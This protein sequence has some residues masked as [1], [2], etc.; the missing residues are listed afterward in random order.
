MPSVHPRR[1]AQRRDRRPRRPRQDH[2]RRRHA[3][4]VRRL[5]RPPGRRGLGQ[6]AGHGLDGPR[7]REG[8]HDPRQEHRGPV[9][10]RRAGRRRDDQHHRH[11]R[12]RRLR[13]RGRARPGDGRR[14]RCCSSTPARARCRRPGS[15]CAR[16]CR[17]GCRSSW[18]STRSTAPTRA[19]PRS[20]TRP[21]SC[22]STSTPTRSR[23][24]SRS[25]TPRPRPAGPSL[26]RPADGDDARLPT[27]SSRCSTTIL[28][29]DPGARRTTEGAPLQAHVTNL[30]ASP[31]LGRLALCRVHNG[32]IRKGQTGRLVPRRRHR[33]SGS[34]SPSC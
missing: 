31:Y 15:C 28:E 6:R 18:S 5:H 8:H 14:R 3:L 2:A 7:A 23:S 24:S 34:R 17:S 32:T 21:T 9:H 11:P 27:T 13:R 16:R 19:S 33:S 1:P 12:P 29:H 30:D 26:T 22:S 25:S 20:S 10:G 4:A